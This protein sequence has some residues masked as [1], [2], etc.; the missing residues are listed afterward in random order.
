[1][2]LIFHVSV[3]AGDGVPNAEISIV[4]IS[5]N[6]LI[7]MTRTDKYG[8][9]QFKTKSVLPKGMYAV[10]IKLIGM[11]NA[12]TKAKNYQKYRLSFQIGKFVK[13]GRREVLFKKET[14]IS[15][16]KLNRGKKLKAILINLPEDIPL[17]MATGNKGGF[18]VGG[19]SAA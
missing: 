16:D 18:A 2:T 10:Y 1:M 19:F 5:G 8:K 13:S 14:L 17:M 15:S 7:A 12:S 3:Y 4:K 6:Q 9:F 11:N